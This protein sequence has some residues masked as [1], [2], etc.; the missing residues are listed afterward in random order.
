VS[1]TGTGDI[2]GSSK[3]LEGGE[4]GFST[5]EGTS[6]FAVDD[7]LGMNEEKGGNFK[8]FREEKAVIC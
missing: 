7:L 2:V 8:G 4:G 1:H 6:T 3:M 5:M